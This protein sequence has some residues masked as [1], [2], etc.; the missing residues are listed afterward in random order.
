MRV[1]K[2][3][4]KLRT[5]WFWNVLHRIP[6]NA[7]HREGNPWYDQDWHMKHWALDYDGNSAI[8]PTSFGGKTKR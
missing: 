5:W 1:P 6:H 7:F 2:I 8:V 3:L 4:I